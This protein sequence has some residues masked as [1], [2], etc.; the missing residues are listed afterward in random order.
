MNNSGIE[1]NKKLL[2]CLILSLV[3]ESGIFSIIYGLN[4]AH[5]VQQV[6]KIYQKFLAGERKMGKIDIF[7]LITPT[8]EPNR[9]YGADYVIVD[10]NGD[11]IPELHIP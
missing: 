10:S 9:Q 3:L 11:G 5:T 4:K 6:V 1:K 8:N 2:V 7:Y